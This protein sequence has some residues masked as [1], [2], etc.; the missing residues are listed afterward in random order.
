MTFLLKKYYGKRYSEFNM[1]NNHIKIFNNFIRLKDELIRTENKNEF[2]QNS[3]DLPKI[4]RKKIEHNLD[5]EEE[6]K[7]AGDI[8]LKNFFNKKLEV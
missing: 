6:L 8:F 4:T 2:Y 7:S 3:E 1:K 5:N